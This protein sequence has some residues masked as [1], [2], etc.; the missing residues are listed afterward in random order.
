MSACASG[1]RLAAVEFRASPGV[2]VDGDLDLSDLR[3]DGRAA[4]WG[5]SAEDWNATEDEH[6]LIRPSSTASGG[7]LRLL[8]SFRGIYPAELT[9]AWVPRTVPALLPAARRDPLGLEVTGVDGSDRP[10]RSAGRVILIPTMPRRS[11][12]VDLDAISRGAEI[13]FDAHAE[14]WLVDD[15]ELVAA[16]TRLAARA[17]DRRRRRTPLPDSPAVATRTRSPPGASHWVPC[18]DRP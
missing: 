5:T 15:P 8:L 13:T 4:D 16:V 7:A 17:R 9:P 12:L 6:T 14:V 3:V 1:C 10:A 18:S 2:E 11:A